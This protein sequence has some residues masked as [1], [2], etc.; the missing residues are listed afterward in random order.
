MAINK[1]EHKCDKCNNSTADVLA[2]IGVGY[3]EHILVKCLNCFKQHK[4]DVNDER[5]LKFFKNIRVETKKKIIKKGFSKHIKKLL[6]KAND[7]LKI[8]TI[9]C[10]KKDLS[11]LKGRKTKTV[12]IIGGIMAESADGELRVDYSYETLLKQIK[13]SLMPEL[14]QILFDKK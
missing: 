13:E 3:R 8:G 1:I 4:L 11:L 9:Y 10:N 2:R 6:E 12:E 7:E 5:C 14:N